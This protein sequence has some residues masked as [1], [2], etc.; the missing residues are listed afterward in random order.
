M[1]STVSDNK[2]LMRLSAD[3]CAQLTAELHWLASRPGRAWIRALADHVSEGA[4]LGGV[5]VGIV[6]LQVK[7]D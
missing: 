4:K 7:A 2:S 3:E 1:A 5:L 6:A